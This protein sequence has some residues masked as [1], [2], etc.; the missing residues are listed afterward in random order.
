MSLFIGGLAFEAAGF[1]APVRLGV[2]GGSILAAV[3]GYI[4]LRFAADQQSKPPGVG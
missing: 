3:A 2:L 4:V 1:D